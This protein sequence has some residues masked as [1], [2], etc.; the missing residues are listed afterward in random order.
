[1]P[2]TQGLPKWIAGLTCIRLMASHYIRRCWRG[3]RGF[4]GF[5][6][7]RRGAVFTNCVVRQFPP[8]LL[9]VPMQ[10]S[11][12][13]PPRVSICL[14]IQASARR[15]LR[16]PTFEPSQSGLQKVTKATKSLPPGSGIKAVSPF[17]SFVSFC[18]S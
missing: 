17:V 13:I 6:H 16:P 11:I 1:V 5:F 15:Q 2:A 12:L 4:A 7:A 8:I 14:A 9:P 10:S 18:N 3:K